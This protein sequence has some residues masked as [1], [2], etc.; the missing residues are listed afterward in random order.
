MPATTPKQR[1]TAAIAEHHPD[2]LYAR[3]RGMLKMSHQQ[4]HDYA[5]TKGLGKSGERHDHTPGDG[6]FAHHG[7]TREGPH[8]SE[9]T[10]QQT[11]SGGPGAGRSAVGGFRNQ[12]STAA[13]PRGGA[14]TKTGKTMG[15]PT[16]GAANVGTFRTAA[17][18]GPHA[19]SAGASGRSAGVAAHQEPKAFR[20]SGTCY[21]GPN[22]RSRAAATGSAT[23]GPG[24]GSSRSA[25]FRTNME[26]RSTGTAGHFGLPLSRHQPGH[27]TGDY[28]AARPNNV[29]Q[30][31]RIRGLEGQQ[32]P[33]HGTTKTPPQAF[34][35]AGTTKHGTKFLQAARDRMKAKGTEGAFTRAA[36]KAGQSVQAHARSVLNNPHASGLEKKRANFARVAAK[37]ARNR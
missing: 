18:D 24:A 5:A 10:S 8:L 4:L 36:G 25:G 13:T 21:P 20:E 12:G 22:E 32:G 2:E 17:K 30:T 3:N 23:G 37:I 19:G 15:G 35:N 31:D 33:K 7:T 1:V 11:A 26:G 28:A 34:R 27:G 16:G 29:V 9:G 6:G 14:S